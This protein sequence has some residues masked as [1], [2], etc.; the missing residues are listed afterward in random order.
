M[1]PIQGQRTITRFIDPNDGHQSY[2]GSIEP[3]RPRDERFRVR[4]WWETTQEKVVRDMN[5]ELG[6]VPDSAYEVIE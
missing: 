6:E 1:E 4:E 2:K 5:K 3:I